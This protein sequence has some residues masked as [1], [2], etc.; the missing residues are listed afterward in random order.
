M[1]GWTPTTERSA[2]GRRATKYPGIR[3]AADGSEAVVWVEAHL[4]QAACVHSVPPAN[5]MADRFE[6][7][8]AKGGRNLWD[9]PLVLRQAESGYGAA[10]MCEGFALAGGRVTSF[11]GGQDLVQMAE[12]LFTAA[13]KRLPMVFHVASGALASQA[14]TIQAG[15]DDICAI[16]DCG[17]GILFARNAQEAADL[18]VIARRAAELA[19]TPFLN[20][21]DGFITTHGLETVHLPEP[22][23]MKVF[24]GAPQ[25]RVRNVFDPGQPLIT[26]PLENQDSYMRGRIAQRYF[27]ERVRPSLETAMSD[28]AELT[29]R[30]Y[31]PVRCHRMEDAEFAIVGLGSL[32]DTAEA[33]VEYLRGQ[34]IRVG[35]LAITTLRPFPAA[36]IVNAVAR[37]RGITVVERTDTP[38][39]GANPLTGQ[40]K[41][42]L[43]AAQM[44][45]DARLLRVPEVFS[46]AAGVGGRAVTAASLAAAIENMTRNGRRFFVLGIKH[47]DAITV[48]PDLDTRPPGA[49]T[50]RIHSRAGFGSTSA[51]RLIGAIASE[52]FGV[53]V[54]AESGYRGEERTA[55]VSA[56]VTFAPKRIL[57][58]CD[59]PVVDAVAVHH[60]E[61]FEHSDPLAGLRPGGTLFVETG[62]PVNEVWNSLPVE[63]RRSLRERSTDLFVIDASGIANETAATPG[64]AGRARGLALLGAFLKIAPWR[65][66][67][68]PT[69]TELAAG[70]ERGVTRLF[71]HLGPAVVAEAVS[72]ARRGYDEVRLVIPPEQITDY[73]T[74]AVRNKRRNGFRSLTEGDLVPAGFCEHVIH[75]YL[76]GRDSVL[77]SDLY[78]ARS[79]LP[80]G[81]SELRS[82]RQLAPDIPRFSPKHCTG[83]MECV[84]LCPDSAIFARVV[85]PETVGHAPPEIHAQF[86]FTAKYYE[87]Y[88]KKGETGGLFG[89]YI[90]ADRCKGCGEC[91]EVCGSRK[92]LEM[93]P[94]TQVDLELYDRARE[95][96]ENLPDTPARFINEKSL[97]D[98]LLSSRARLHTGGAA[99]CMG[100]GESS[101][102]R[103]LLAA[104][105]FTYGAGQV[106]VVAASGCHTA[107]SASYPFSPFKISWTNTLASNAP[108]DAI[109]I[110]MKWDRDGQQRRRLW[111]LGAE[112][113][114]LGSGL[115]SLYS[116]LESG[117]DIK[118][119]MLDKSARSPVGELGL[120]L[121]MRRNALVAQT[122]A[123]H[124]NHFYKSVV[125]ANE[126]P[127]PAVVICY[128][129]CTT[130]HGIGDDQAAAQ[131]RLAVDSRTFPIFMCDPR[132]GD[133]LRERLDLRGNPSLR[134]DWFK[135][136]KSGNPVDFFAYARSEGRFAG[137]FNASGEPDATLAAYREAVLMNW[138]H[139]QE[140]GGLR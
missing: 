3:R 43:A 116:L 103:M 92:A 29:G 65:N 139:L 79:I 49:Y 8:A 40:L 4:S 37:C 11:T 10:S 127:G 118:V 52:V 12:V 62:L 9:E 117:L 47:S 7:E 100:C 54:K 125:A 26:S 27:Y 85:D 74:G 45:E 39:A 2:A 69:E 93:A 113:A 133:R 22:E 135:D 25:R 1:A 36:E 41:A 91:V 31:G 90:D 82:F 132:A 58:N 68:T 105:G 134:E 38:L 51:A 98:I 110:R 67:N 60:V 64:R 126:Y 131:A 19:E 72:I 28:F 59:P 128:S 5:R 53:E 122:T 95:F 106:G 20:V 15:H 86:A 107:A 42:A 78:V 111:V 109:G 77:D 61:A 119:L 81:S 108:S 17:W 120:P 32:M 73:Q 112:D 21:Q 24:V 46:G 23:L 102:I 33:A 94:K 87:A 18:A 63:V 121:M 115:N 48:G 83:C 96:F 114:L 101:A 57:A 104:S 56:C 89:L 50:L 123:A 124:I 138:R 66:P 84:N 34:G 99:S 137:H 35:S 76:E 30:R 6:R 140:L 75:N 88:L 130:D 16:A 55:P 129:A 136:P 14:L 13:G 70:I 97:A 44:G 80:P 71:E